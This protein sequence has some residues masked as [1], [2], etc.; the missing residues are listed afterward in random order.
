MKPI[1]AL[2][3]SLAAAAASAQDAT[4]VKVQGRVWIRPAGAAKDLVAKGGEELLYGDAVRTGANGRA[5]VQ[6]GDKGA[7]LVRE[8]SA[9]LLDG[10][11]RHPLVR[12]RFGEFLIGLRRRLYASETF[13]VK[14]PSAVA[15]VRGTL[16][17]GKVGADK[18]TTYAGLENVIAVTGKTRTVELAAGQSTTVPLGGEPADPKPHDIAPS[19]LQHFAVGGSLEGLDDLLAK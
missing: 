13:R 11:E 16:F 8:N 10:E 2:V 14:T 1:L 17:W 12:F 7:I 5:H 6:V 4:L 15:A 19:Y 3:L 18:S 9:F